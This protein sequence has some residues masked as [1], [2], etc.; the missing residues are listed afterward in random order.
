MFYLWG[1]PTGA[2][3]LLFTSALDY[4]LGK[5][6]SA[7]SN[8]FKKIVLFFS[9]F[10]NIAL[11]FYFKYMD[12]FVGE[13]NTLLDHFQIANIP[14]K[15]IA[16]PIG[17]SFIIFHKI[18]YLVDIYHQKA[19]AAKTFLDFLLYIVMFPK[20]I[21]GPIICYYDFSHQIENIE[22]KDD[23]RFNG[24]FRFCVGLAKKTLIADP[25]GIVADKVFGLGFDSMTMS[26]SWLG[27]LCYTLQIYFDFSGYS[28]MAIG[29]GKMMGVKINENF[30]RPY[31]AQNFTD[32][33]RRWHITL[34]NWFKNYLYIPLGGNR[35][36]SFRTY[37]NL[38]IVF[39]TSGLWHGANW[40][41]IIWGAYH[42]L[43]LV[44][45]KLFWLKVSDRLG[46]ILTIPLTFLFVLIGW[47]I[48]RSDSIGSAGQY[49]FR[50][51]DISSINNIITD[52]L[53]VELI[54][55]RQ[56]FILYIALIISFFPE[57]GFETIQKKIDCYKAWSFG[58]WIKAIVT[59]SLIWLSLIS[60]ANNSFSPF[61]YLRF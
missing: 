13:F 18:S 44:A 21:Q 43:F 56:M 51:F 54:G 22:P 15:S 53:R 14:F 36:S 61:I 52:V 9:I 48:F 46:K 1:T 2:L 59:L 20:L 4:F 10:E 55:N 27:A 38:W 45:D 49:L 39:L 58:I 19:N 28:D 7:T 3:I 40:T 11:L 41:F 50:M 33:W 26:Y 12:F 34:S 47:V 8:Q 17:I 35:K 29:I 32:F 60:L 5:V 57:S 30:N 23:D 16:F 24:F 6:I 37:V 25:L 42:G 31:I